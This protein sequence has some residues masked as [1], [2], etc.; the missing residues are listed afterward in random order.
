MCILFED[1]EEAVDHKKRVA[2]FEDG[3][4][5][6][7]FVKIVT[8]TIVVL[9]VKIWKTFKWV[10]SHMK[11]WVQRHEGSWCFLLANLHLIG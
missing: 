3:G 1:I 8:V 4:T 9:R 5:F 6:D 11:L 10:S 7:G 2:S